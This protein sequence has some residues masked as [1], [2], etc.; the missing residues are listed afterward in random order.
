MIP[1]FGG[2]K[3]AV[4]GTTAS[5]V[6]D[7]TLALLSAT[8]GQSDAVNG[9]GPRSLPWLSGSFY[10]FALAL[11]TILALVIAKS[12]DWKALPAVLI[13]GL[14]AVSV[15]GALQLRHDGILSEKGFLKLMAESFKRLPLL[16]GGRSNSSKVS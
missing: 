4:E 7:V 16:Q 5:E 12:V 8:K 6:K 2:W 1:V 13:F 10:L 14:L 9:G 3:V 15:I 11:L